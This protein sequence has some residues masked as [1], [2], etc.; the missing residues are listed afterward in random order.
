MRIVAF[1]WYLGSIKDL[2]KV[3]I[4][5]RLLIIIGLLQRKNKF[6]YSAG[7]PCQKRQSTAKGFLCTVL[8]FS[9]VAFREGI[10]NRTPLYNDRSRGFMMPA[11]F[12]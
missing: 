3:L 12:S 2:H 9:F 5:I 11:S 10:I 4:I 1:Q 7:T 8:K 6:V